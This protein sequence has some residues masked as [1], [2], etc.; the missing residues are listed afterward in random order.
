M[1]G[2]VAAFFGALAIGACSP[3]HAAVRYEFATLVPFDASSYSPQGLVT[4]SFSYTST[5]FINLNLPD[6]LIIFSGLDSC[7]VTSSNGPASCS[8]VMFQRTYLIDPYIVLNEIQFSV[9]GNDSHTSVNTYFED[10]AFSNPG[11]YFTLPMF[12]GPSARLIV[13][14]LNESMVP[15]PTC[16]AMMIIGFG[17]VGMTL[18]RRLQKMALCA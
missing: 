7:T 17:T 3:A 10:G 4:A 18:R 12:N 14:N 13:T 11:T 6:Y 2:L 15:E 8:Y 5:D 16:W 9:V 1:R